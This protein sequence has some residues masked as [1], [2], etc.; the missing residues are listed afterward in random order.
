MGDQATHVYGIEGIGNWRGEKDKKKKR[1][2]KI[3]FFKVPFS[4]M[5]DGL[6]LE[7]QDKRN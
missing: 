4:V 6:A 5:N 2:I 1:G 3:G 7:G